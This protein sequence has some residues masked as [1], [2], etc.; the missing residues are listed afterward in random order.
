[1]NYLLDTNIISETF[2]NKPNKNLLNWLRNIPSNNVYTSVL[3]LGEIRKGIESLANSSKK[4]RI[5][6]WLERDLSNWFDNRI[7]TVDVN[8]AD[9]WGY[10]TAKKN[11]NINAID[12]LIAA[13]CLVNNMTLI[14]R[15]VKDFNYEGLELI[16][17]FDF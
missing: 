15:N 1:M 5:L 11:K 16:N 14:T 7:L 8:V 2:R 10:I 17:P 13:T 3:V 12:S 6:L 4:Q 9:K